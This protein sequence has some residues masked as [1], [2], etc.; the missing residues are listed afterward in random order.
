MPFAGYPDFETCVKKNMKK[1]GWSRERAS[2]YCAAI[3]RKVEGK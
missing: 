2:A 1:F 3:Q